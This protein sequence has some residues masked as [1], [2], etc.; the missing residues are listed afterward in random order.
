MSE[1]PLY[2]GARR[3]GQGRGSSVVY[4]LYRGTLL[5]RKC[6]SPRW[7][8][9][10]WACSVGGRVAGAL[11]EGARVREQLANLAVTVLHVPCLLDSGT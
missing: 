1:V 8:R 7:G 9:G 3:R 11:S 6:P 5:I 10:T 2:L 4:V